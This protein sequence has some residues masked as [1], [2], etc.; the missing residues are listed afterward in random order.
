MTV[1]SK[2]DQLRSE[3]EKGRTE[4]MRLEQ[5]RQEIYSSMLRISGAIQVLEE[6]ENERKTALNEVA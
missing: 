6:M 2:L 3:L 1:N 5:R 4:L